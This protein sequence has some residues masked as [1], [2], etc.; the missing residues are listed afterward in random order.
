[1]MAAALKRL[2]ARVAAFFSG[3]ALDRDFDQEL[4]SHLAMQT[5]ENIASGM[6][7]EEARRAARIRFGGEQSIRQQHREARGLP[8]LDDLVQDLRFAV[9]LIAKERWFSA[10]AAA[11]LALGIGVNAIGFTI[12]NVSFFKPLALPD[13]ARL[14][15]LV[16]QTQSVR[17]FNVS[18]V[19]LQDWRQQSR[20][21][22]GL[23]GY[24]DA[25]MNFSDDRGWPEQ[26][27]GTSVTANLFGQ[28]GQQPLIGRDFA[29]ADEPSG[30]E[31]VAIIGDR[32]W[33]RR[34]GRDPSVIGKAVR[35]DGKPV[36]IVGVM[37][38]GMRFPDS[39]EVWVVFHPTPDQER[40][41]ARLFRVVGRL[42][43]GASPSAAEAELATVAQRLTV[44]ARRQQGLT[45]VDVEPPAEPVRRPRPLR[46]SSAVMAAVNCSCC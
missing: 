39:S 5:D 36:T 31:H 21:F 3:R 22:E 24:S 14:Y 33:Q 43:N 18:Y 20:S 44:E 9:R 35:L 38:G 10:V 15:A 37:P 41:D 27:Q 6:T 26:V 30:A 32:F 11:T 46:C 29:P 42:R 12:D 4:A 13:P 45:G 17:R 25:R 16:W 23:A 19:D 8:M 40:R 7:P 28:L 1:M 2:V 34:Y